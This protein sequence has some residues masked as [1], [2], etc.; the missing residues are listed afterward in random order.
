MSL[1][2]KATKRAVRARIALDGPS[3]SG[4]TWTALTFANVFG[5]KTALVD[6]ERGSASL[7]ADQFDFDVIELSPP[8]HPQR[9]IDLV[10]AA[11]KEHYDTLIV[12]SG[13]HFWEGEGGTLDIVDAASARAQG[14]TWAGWKTGTPI[15]RDLIDTMLASDLHIIF[16]MRSKTEWV[17][18]EKQNR[19]GKTVTTPR[20][21]GMAPVMRAGMEYEFTLVGDLDLEHRLTISKSRVAVLADQVIQPGRASDAAEAFV[22]W[23]SSGS[24]VATREQIDGL[25]Q[26]INRIQPKE[27]RVAAK[28]SFADQFGNPDYLL[29][30]KIPA[31]EAFIAGYD[32]TSDATPNEGGDDDGPGGKGTPAP[33]GPATMAAAEDGTRGGTSNADDVGEPGP[34][35]P[36]AA[37]VSASPGDTGSSA[38]PGPDT[39]L[40]DTAGAIADRLASGGGQTAQSVENPTSVQGVV[41]NSPAP[42]DTNTHYPGPD[43]KPR[44]QTSPGEQLHRDLARSGIKTK[45]EQEDIIFFASSGRTVHAAE[46]SLDERTAAL[47]CADDIDEGRFTM[48]S[49]LAA[50]EAHRQQTLTGQLEQSIAQT[51]ERA[52]ADFDHKTA[53]AS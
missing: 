32:G 8:Y 43:P 2:Q 17:L 45:T 46:L 41:S 24:A 53:W 30:E 50:N 3:G 19:D 26:R 25:K 40:R 13:S 38:A 29:A 34:E 33:N 51:G 15:L 36:P 27:V 9:L 47:F 37:Q 10:E 49:V 1:F 12:D 4:K 23:M 16:T 14:N 39:N 22:A 21:V 35:S 31:A 52:A 44:R 42:R 5:K 7:Y 18:E 20:R 28:Q 6:T 11:E 48:A